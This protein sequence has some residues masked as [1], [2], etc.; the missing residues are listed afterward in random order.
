MNVKRYG[1]WEEDGIVVHP[2]GEYV[3]YMDYIALSAKLAEVQA[4]RDHLSEYADH[5]V[6]FS[7]MPCLPKDLE[8]LREAN[9]KLAEE[10]N[11]W[12]IYYL[13]A[14]SKLADIN[15]ILNN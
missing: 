7:K 8:N 5:L 10:T 14:Q 9:T 12:K 4:E 2:E 1:S 11:T 13:N 3:S 6:S 15:T